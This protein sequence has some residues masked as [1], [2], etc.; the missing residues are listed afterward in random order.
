M[1]KNDFWNVDESELSD[2]LTQALEAEFNKTVKKYINFGIFFLIIKSKVYYCY[3]YKMH[4][5][6]KRKSLSYRFKAK[7]E[8]VQVIT[9]F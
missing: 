3:R 8:D 7:V 2:S 4:E 5:S 9:I 1:D 6:L